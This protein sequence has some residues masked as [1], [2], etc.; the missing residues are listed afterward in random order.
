MRFS[1][2]CIICDL[3]SLSGAYSCLLHCLVCPV[4]INAY[5]I[6]RYYMRPRFFVRYC[7][8]LYKCL[9]H[10]LNYMKSRFCVHSLHM[11]IVKLLLLATLIVK[12]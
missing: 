3:V 2:S 5:Y 11:E 6:G 8:V 10:C 4:L 9:L 7:L 1:L 12:Y